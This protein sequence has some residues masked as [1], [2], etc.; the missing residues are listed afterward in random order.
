MLKFEYIQH[1]NIQDDNT[2]IFSLGILVNSIIY[3][4]KKYILFDNEQFELELY[5]SYLTEEMMKENIYDD[6]ST[7]KKFEIDYENFSPILGSNLYQLV[8]KN[9]IK[10]KTKNK[11]LN[12]EL[13][14]LNNEIEKY[15]NSIKYHNKYILETGEICYMFLKSDFKNNISTKCYNMIYEFILTKL[16]QKEYDNNILNNIITE[17][18]NHLYTFISP[19]NIENSYKQLALRIFI[20][21]FYLKESNFIELLHYINNKFHLLE[22]YHQDF[23]YD[24]LKYNHSFTRILYELDHLYDNVNIENNELI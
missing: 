13:I 14:E 23:L 15:F 7:F 24:N 2:I 9:N 22:R 11:K 8:I 1:E 3:K 21:I 19:N 18:T 16:K 10:L 5:S 17:L 20:I 12:K 6:Y 4:N